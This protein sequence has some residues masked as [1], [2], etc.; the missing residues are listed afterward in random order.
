MCCYADPKAKREFLKKLG[1]RKTFWG[2][3]VL[4]TDGLALFQ[5]YQYRAGVNTT[6]AAKRYNQGRPGGLHTYTAKPR[7]SMAEDNETIVRVQCHRDDL[8]C[9][10]D[11][12]NMWGSNRQAVL[13]KL[14]ILKKDWLAAGLPKEAVK[15]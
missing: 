7:E 8:I 5:P 14:T 4:I 12:S 9:V 1:K 6:K 2:W 10:E 11:V 15:R 3:K 13:R